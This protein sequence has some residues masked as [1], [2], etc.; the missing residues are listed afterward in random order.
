[1]V[2]VRTL[3]AATVL[4]LAL[5]G[6][7]A[8]QTPISVGDNLAGALDTNDLQRPDATYF[9][10]YRVRVA[11][12]ETTITVTSSAFD[13]NLAVSQVGGGIGLED[14]NGGGGT[15]AKVV[16]TAPSGGD[17]DIRVSATDGAPGA[18]QIKIEAGKR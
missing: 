2:I 10:H 14:D 6:Q 13:A 1:L 8:A 7:A 5:A 12:G 16:L 9:D 3:I 4:C 11:A 18:Y 15:T 17:F